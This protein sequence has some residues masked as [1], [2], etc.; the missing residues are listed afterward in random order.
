MAIKAQEGLHVCFMFTFFHKFFLSI[1][2]QQTNLAIQYFNH[3][4][5]LSHNTNDNTTHILIIIHPVN[6][7][8]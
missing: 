8:K 7:T 5:L 6:E 4:I 2:V 1:Y 3:S